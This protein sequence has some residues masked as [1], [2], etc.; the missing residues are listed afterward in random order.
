MDLSSKYRFEITQT[1]GALGHD[2][3]ILI[4]CR[5]YSNDAERVNV[6][7][8][9]FM[10]PLKESHTSIFGIP[11][12]TIYIESLNVKIKYK[13]QRIGHKII[14]EVAKF[15]M[16]QKKFAHI[17]SILLSA[18]TS[19]KTSLERGKKPHMLAEYYKSLGFN[20]IDKERYEGTVFVQQFQ[21]GIHEFLKRCDF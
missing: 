20:A 5:I 16:D 13:G 9:D 2:C 10:V 11:P 4:K 18:T 1:D 17:N 14:C 19:R 15:V 8:A 21:I 6:G 3:L 7:S 12:N